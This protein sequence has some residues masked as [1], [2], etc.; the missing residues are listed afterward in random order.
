MVEK[1]YQRIA[2]T[3]VARENCLA[4]G[5]EWLTRHTQRIVALVREFMPS[6][7]GFDKGTSLDFDKSTG[8]K[9]VF[10]TAFHH[11][12]PD[13][14]YDGWTDHVVTVHPSL[15][16]GIDV[17][18]GGSDRRNIKDHIG[19][20]FESALEEEVPETWETDHGL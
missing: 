9:L 16:Y 13:G 6:G 5:N 4:H 7:S 8:E 17:R 2:K 3:L 20:A 18:V 15:T 11:M 10:V 1:L 12:T 19:A 14:Y